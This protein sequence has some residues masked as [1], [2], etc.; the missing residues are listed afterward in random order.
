MHHDT[1]ELRGR[2]PRL[3]E[4]QTVLFLQGPLSALFGLIA[5]RLTA[6][7]HEC[8]RINVSPGD[9]AFWGL[10]PATNW[11]GR[12]ADWHDF[13]D[14]FLAERGVTAVVMHS[15]RRVYHRIAADKARARGIDVI[16]TEL[17]YL[18]PDWMT[19]EKNGNS[20]D[21]LFPVDPRE[22]REIAAAV[23]AAGYGVRFP[24]SRGLET[25][26]ELRNSLPNT[27]AWFLYPHYERHIT[28]HHFTGYRRWMLRELTAA[29]R[30][31]AARE[32]LQ[33]LDERR[34]PF[35]LFVMQTDGD[36]QIR[37]N[38]QFED[39]RHA[40]GATLA[41][42]ATHAP[43]GH[44][45][46]FKNH[47][48]DTGGTDW[49][50]V[51]ADLAATYGVSRRVH[52][53]DGLAMGDYLAKAVGVV[54]VNSSAGIDALAAGRPTI[55][56]SPSIFDIEGLTFQGGLD[57]FWRAGAPPDATLFA[58]FRSALAASVQVRG[59]IY[60]R[61]GLVA[62]ADAMAERIDART[63]NEPGAARAT[64]PPRHAKAIRL[65]IRS[66][67]GEGAPADFAALS[68]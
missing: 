41:S 44:A 36:F 43:A 4:R 35:F 30:A 39:M 50:R 61:E 46:V 22:I 26:D 59:S 7:G 14:R 55:S 58:A 9:A 28:H 29:R 5:D 68:G 66:P 52:F 34:T 42:F 15:E 38:S 12:V 21:S 3:D 23:P 33:C 64:V 2:R 45:I 31:R 51:M 27:F 63:V 6:H 47:P 67:R 53:V 49:P 60:S 37:A 20:V 16:V 17:G 11:R 25:V 57:A 1:R 48:L 24:V 13:I 40:I 32:V 8:L 19:I 62:A 56:L 18:R 54:T 10:R 65:G